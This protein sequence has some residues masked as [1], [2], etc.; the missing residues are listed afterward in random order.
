MNIE[1]GTDKPAQVNVLWD[2]G[3]TVSMITFKRATELKLRGHRVRMTIT[4]IG[5]DKEDIDSY[6]YSVPLRDLNGE[7]IYFD[8][9]GIERISTPLE[10]IELGNAIKRF[11]GV[12]ESDVRREAGEVDMLIG[13]EYAGYHPEKEQSIQH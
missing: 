11:E 8:A 10:K 7:V 13:F 2:G 12:N 1:T 3:A 5:G 6:K 9:Y 4:K